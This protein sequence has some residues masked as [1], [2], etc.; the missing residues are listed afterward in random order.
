[1]ALSDMVKRLKSDGII[2][3]R[4]EKWLRA[5]GDIVPTGDILSRLSA[6][7]STPPR[8][9]SSSFSASSRGSCERSQ[10]FGYIGVEGINTIDSVLRNLFNDGT[11]RHL[12]WQAML[13]QSKMIDDIE[14]KLSV[15]EYRLKGSMDGVGTY[16]TKPFGWELK[17]I[18]SLSKV[19]H[20]PLP[21]H[22]LQIHSYMFASGLDVFSLI[23]EDKA[24]QQWK[25][26]TVT[27]DDEI[28][29]E[30]T[31][32]LKVL[33][34]SVSDKILP[35]I[36]EECENGK[37]YTYN[38]CSYKEFCLGCKDY[39][40]AE[41]QADGKKERSARVANREIVKARRLSR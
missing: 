10:V 1:M 2:T 28:M 19:K 33:N 14:V 15:P 36:L 35:D 32:E 29:I 7:M 4:L 6:V 34:D 31:D 40:E 38:S 13:L 26:Y 16:D 12:R 5:E 27:V 23:Y 25:E 18:R 3:P 8:D 24:N 21:Y 39:A 41:E 22:L 9:R 30:V 11:W 20:E 37:G 17:G